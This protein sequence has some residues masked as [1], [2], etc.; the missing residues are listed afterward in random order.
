MSVTGYNMDADLQPEHPQDNCTILSEA[1]FNTALR[2][3]C[4]RTERSQRSFVL[5][6]ASPGSG[7]PDDGWKHTMEEFATALAMTCRETDIIGWYLDGEVMGAIFN[8]LGDAEKNTIKACLQQKIHAAFADIR[9]SGQ[10]VHFRFHFFPDDADG[11]SWLQAEMHRKN[12]APSF[13]QGL[14]R[15]ID[16]TASA[17]GLVLLSPLLCVISVLIKLTST[18]PVLFRQTRLGQHGKEFTF[19]KF[20][21]MY[22]NNDDSL[23]QEYVSQLIAGK[24]K[25][26][27]SAD[28]TSS[29]YK[30]IND[31]RITPLGRVLRKMSLDELPQLFNV[32]RGEMSL[33]G[34]RPPL[35]YE[36]A[37][38]DVWHLRR[39]VE[40]K[41]GITGLWQVTGRSKTSF[42]DMVR[43]DLRYAKRWS[44]SLDFKILLRTFRVV[45]SG[46]GAY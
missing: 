14:K 25:R 11:G 13:A 5:V 4:R 30:V 36:W 8:E 37:C 17:L 23:H 43:L 6:L 18:G 42:D 20:R 29:A 3:E 7:A 39:I 19:L 26:K 27:Q 1:S 15:V 34:P 12:N 41:P 16:I 9:R 31:P 21:S 24:A 2:K 38:Y 32:L 46:D 33:V 10:T 45:F 35:P 40:V 44:L 22:V 28:G